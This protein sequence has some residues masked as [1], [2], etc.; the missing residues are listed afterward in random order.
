MSEHG[1]TQK[2]GSSPLTRGALAPYVLPADR[3]GII[4]A[5]AGSTVMDPSAL[6]LMRDH[7]RSRGEHGTLHKRRDRRLG[8]SPLTRGAHFEGEGVGVAEGIIPAHAGSTASSALSPHS[9]WDHPRSREEHPT[10]P[11]RLLGQQ[12]SSPLTRGAPTK[13]WG[14]S[15]RLGIIPAHAGS[16]TPM[17]LRRLST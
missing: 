2:A 14:V 13:P 5:H 15:W 17:R 7:P 9:T 16:T 12:G 11:S 3:P 4:P 10:P 8:S 6:I 1:V